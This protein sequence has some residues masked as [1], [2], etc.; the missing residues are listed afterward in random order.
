MDIPIGKVETREVKP[1][2]DRT[3]AL[4]V[5]LAEETRRANSN[6]DRCKTLVEGLENQLK[7]RDEKIA[8]LNDQVLNLTGVIAGMVPKS[9]VTQEEHAAEIFA[10]AV[11]KINETAIAAAHGAIDRVTAW[12]SNGGNDFGPYEYVAQYGDKLKAEIAV[13]FAE[14]YPPK[15]YSRD[16]KATVSQVKEVTE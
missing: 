13:A 1:R 2:T 10:P 15:S 5:E 11:A 9:T 12:Y 4:L 16:R 8:R 7:H 14:A 6:Y 3:E